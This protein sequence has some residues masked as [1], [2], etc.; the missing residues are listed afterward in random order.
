MQG[1]QLT[2]RVITSQFLR[3]PHQLWKY[4]YEVLSNESEFCGN[5]DEIFSEIYLR[6]DTSTK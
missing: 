1:Q 5:V 3:S 2:I 6:D 4:K